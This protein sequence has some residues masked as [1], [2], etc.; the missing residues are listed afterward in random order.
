MNYTGTATELLAEF[1]L[2]N[3]GARLLRM[4]AATPQHLTRVYFCSHIPGDA[5]ECVL[6]L[7]ELTQRTIRHELAKFQVE[8]VAA[9]EG[10]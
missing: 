8:P 10:E 7:E 3:A 9:G 1:I 5:P 4:E 2:Y 6:P